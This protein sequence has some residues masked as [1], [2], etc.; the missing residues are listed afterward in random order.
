MAQGMVCTSSEAI[1]LSVHLSI[2]I[3]IP[4]VMYKGSGCSAY[5]QT[6]KHDLRARIC[7]QTWQPS[8]WLNPLGVPLPSNFLEEVCLHWAYILTLQ[9]RSFFMCLQKYAKHWDRVDLCFLRH[10]PKCRCAVCSNPNEVIGTLSIDF[11][12]L[13]NSLRDLCVLAHTRL[14]LELTFFLKKIPIAK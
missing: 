8:P 11:G 14:I 13:W 5:A 7:K 10:F 3:S 2:C 4:Q 12:G 1:C 6:Q 9:Y